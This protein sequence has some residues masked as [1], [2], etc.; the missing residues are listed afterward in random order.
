[1]DVKLPAWEELQA[2]VPF[3][4]KKKPVHTLK[5][6]LPEQRLS[7]PLD[8]AEKT[9][10]QLKK[11]GAKFVSGGEFSDV[12][13]AKPY[14]EGVFAYFIVRVEKKTE[15]ERLLFDGY[16]IQEE[17]PLNLNLSSSFS[18]IEDLSQLGYEQALSRALTE[19]RFLKL[20][21]TL[22]VADVQEFGQFLEIALP[23]TKLQSVRD[24]Q[25]KAAADLLK[26][27][28]VAEKD[29]IPTDLIT[30]QWLSEQQKQ[31][32]AKGQNDPGN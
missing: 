29:A 21:L 19:G 20:P 11:M 10:F 30:L 13:H 7:L 17:E 28:G 1:M 4:P 16:M 2:L 15:N 6:K 22:L 12:V 5:W 32:D 25:Q 23:A 18:M 27:L 26:K 24:K 14:G 31:A 8:D 9:V 3:L